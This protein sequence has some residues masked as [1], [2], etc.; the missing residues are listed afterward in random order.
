[1]VSCPAWAGPWLPETGAST[2]V[3]PCRAAVAASRAV[4]SMPM[5]A[6]CTQI[7]PGPP[8][9]N[10]SGPVAAC[11]VADPSASMVMTIPAPLTASAGL[12]ATTAPSLA[13]GAA[14]LAV[15]FQARTAKPPRARL[16]AI[17]A[18]MR[19][20]PRKA[21]AGVEGGMVFMSPA[22]WPPG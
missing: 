18:P 3:T 13:R 20:V 9:R 16:A 12:P 2:K 14:R 21:M 11:S 17:G 4:Q 10:P 6:I 7:S 1:M 15:R 8:A 19:P 22:S 5:V